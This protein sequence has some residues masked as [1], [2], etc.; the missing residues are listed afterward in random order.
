M[1]RLVALPALGIGLPWLVRNVALSGCFVFPAA[2]TCVVDR[3][4]SVGAAS[5]RNLTAWIASW[6]RRPSRTPEEVLGSW[7]WLRTWP[8]LYGTD[9]NRVLVLL[10]AGGVVMW[11][12]LVR[13]VTRSVAVPFAIALAGLAYWFASAPTPRFGYAYVYPLALMPLAFGLSRLAPIR[14]RWIHAAMAAVILLACSATFRSNC[15]GLEDT[16]CTALTGKGGWR[17]RRWMPYREWPPDAPA[18]A[19]EP[20]ILRSG[21]IAFVPTADNR[22]GNAP[23]P[24]TPS[25]DPDLVWLDG[26]FELRRASASEASG[27]APLSPLTS[28]LHPSLPAAGPAHPSVR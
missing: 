27:S 21:Q 6:A 16:A 12:L 3:P 4:W 5:A 2:G 9:E 18:V 11:L 10:F 22:C 26:R 28:P 19:T 8:D 25:L 14:G 1:V 13:A 17:Y 15:G 23:L 24:C 7:D 20:R